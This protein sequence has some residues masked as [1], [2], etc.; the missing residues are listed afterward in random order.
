MLMVFTM[1]IVLN[2]MIPFKIFDQLDITGSRYF[3]NRTA[4]AN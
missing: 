4:A 2:S 1:W 3:V